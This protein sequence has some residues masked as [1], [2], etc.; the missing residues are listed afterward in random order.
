[1]LMQAGDM[2][3]EANGTSVFKPL[4]PPGPE[5]ASPK[6][7]TVKVHSPIPRRVASNESLKALGKCGGGSGGSQ[8]LDDE[9]VRGSR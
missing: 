9:E 6:S 3:D 7:P 4:T 2:K 1:M 8:D 5:S